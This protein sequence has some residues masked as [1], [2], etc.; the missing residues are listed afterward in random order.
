M[1]EAMFLQAF[2]ADQLASIKLPADSAFERDRPRP[3]HLRQPGYDDVY[4]FRTLFYDA[5][6]WRAGCE[7]R[8][9]GPQLLNFEKHVLAGQISLVD[10]D[11]TVPL[12]FALH[13]KRKVAYLDV[14]LP[15]AMQTGPTLRFDFGP[16]GVHVITAN[17]SGLGLFAGHRVAFTMFK[18]ESNTWLR[19]WAYFNAAYHGATAL[20]VYHNACPDRATAEIAEALKGIPNVQVCLVSDWP[21]PF[22]PIDGGTGIWDS[23]Y[24]KPAMFEHARWRFLAE[25]RSVLNTDIDELVITKGHRSIFEIAEQA[26]ERHVRFFG[27]WVTGDQAAR[28]LDTR[29]HK[30]FDKIANDP[31]DIEV[32]PKWAVVPGALTDENRWLI[33]S[34]THAKPLVL[35]PSD[36][37][38]RHFRH[39]NSKWKID[40][41]AVS[42]P[43][44]TDTLLQEAFQKIGWS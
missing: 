23:N 40:R 26:P 20:L 33:H 4:D 43:L 7:V 44:E 5:F 16:L 29:R 9:I 39:I 18:Y 13:H 27:H 28:G 30:D 36:V 42:G 41:F 37:G 10:G 25:A 24:C 3:E 8:L 17:A 32:E 35:Q 14:T 19:D 38:L 15:A 2:D 34:V 12:S 6:L 21:F 31:D 22:G 11:R 1:T